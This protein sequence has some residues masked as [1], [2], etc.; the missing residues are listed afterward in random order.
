MAWQAP[1]WRN[2][3]QH[4]AI[5]LVVQIVAGLAFGNWWAGA[6]LAIGLFLGREHDQAEYRWMK[7]HGTNRAE[8]PWWA[9]KWTFDGLLDWF[10]PLVATI[11]LAALIG[12]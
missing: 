8:K 2:I 7:E 3:A 12:G 6:A 4:S 9:A 10:G 5:A 1:S 11:A